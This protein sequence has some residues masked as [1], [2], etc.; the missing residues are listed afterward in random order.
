VLKRINL[1]IR[2]ALEHVGWQL[3]HFFWRFRG[4][5]NQ[6]NLLPL[7]EQDIKGG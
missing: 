3:K 4:F 5:R 2:Q 6:T 7:R 1:F